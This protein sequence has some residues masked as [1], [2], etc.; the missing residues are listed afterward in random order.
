MQV[1]ERPGWQEILSRLSGT[2]GVRSKTGNKYNTEELQSLFGQ[3]AEQEPG[4]TQAEDVFILLS[5]IYAGG[6]SLVKLKSPKEKYEQE[7]FYLDKVDQK[8]QTMFSA[9]DVKSAQE[10][11]WISRNMNL[12]L[13]PA[14][15]NLY[16]SRIGLKLPTQE[17]PP[18]TIECDRARA[19]KCW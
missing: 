16:N 2:A 12:K 9:A 5:T 13:S 7:S 14:Q 6:G 15:N 19:Q 8:M 4:T 3:P 17:H 1:E 11:K 18:N 10:A